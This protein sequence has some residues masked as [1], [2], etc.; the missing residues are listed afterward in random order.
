LPQSGTGAEWGKGDIP[1]EAK[2]EEEEGAD[3]EAG[4]AAAAAEVEGRAAAVA[5]E[6]EPDTIRSISRRTYIFRHLREDLP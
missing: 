3:S 4:D 1:E 5:G 2:G 6:V